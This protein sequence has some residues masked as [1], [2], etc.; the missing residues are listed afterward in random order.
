MLLYTVKYRIKLDGRH[1]MIGIRGCKPTGKPRAARASASVLPDLYRTLQDVA[2]QKKISVAWVIRDAAEK[3]I[4]DQWPLGG[5]TLTVKT[6]CA[7][8]QAEEQ[9]DTSVPMLEASKTTSSRRLASE[10]TKP[11][12]RDLKQDKLLLRQTLRW[13]PGGISCIFY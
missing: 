2:K 1:E 11:S 12:A 8:Q 3:Y 5:T 10:T 7:T 9:K 6:L 4:V 13:S